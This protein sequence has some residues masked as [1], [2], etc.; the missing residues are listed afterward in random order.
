LELGT[1]KGSDPVS[2][3]KIC[4]SPQSIRRYIMPK[5]PEPLPIRQSNDGKWEVNN[6]SGKWIKCETQEDA[7]IISNAPVIEA[8]WLKTRRP[9]KALAARLENTAEK[10]EQYGMD[11]DARRFRTWAKLA[12]GEG[13]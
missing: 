7:E 6:L 10:L 9:N 11:T 8:L 5:S 13:S 12:R 1:K 2:I 4:E 3:P